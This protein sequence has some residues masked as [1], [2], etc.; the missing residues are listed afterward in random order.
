[1]VDGEHYVKIVKA[2]RVSFQTGSEGLRITLA[3]RSNETISHAIVEGDFFNRN[4][5]EFYDTFSIER[6]DKNLQRW[7]GRY[8]WVKV[9]DGKNGYKQAVLMPEKASAQP[10]R[11]APPPAP[12]PTY[13]APSFNDED[14]PF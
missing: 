4:L 9:K 5:T 8:G 11:N 7:V 12:Q 6:G 14:V 3:N 2:E 13:N 1:M 10:Q